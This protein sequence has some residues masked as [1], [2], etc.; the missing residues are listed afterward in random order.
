MDK[1][2]K[3]KKDKERENE[4]EK[5]SLAKEKLVKKRQSLP[6]IRTRPDPRYNNRDPGSVS[7]SVSPCLHRIGPPGPIRQ[8]NKVTDSTRPLSI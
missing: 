4:K 6:G 1:N 7:V 8:D 2:K 3:E 5:S